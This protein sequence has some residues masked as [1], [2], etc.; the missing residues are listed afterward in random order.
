MAES[1]QR[2][3]NR[4]RFN[5]SKLAIQYPWLTLGF[6]LA[7]MVAGFFAFSSLKYALFP[8]V[9]FPVVV[10][11]A[12]APLPVA[13][14]TEAQVT[15]PIENQVKALE[16][17][18]GLTKIRSSTYPGRSVVSLSFEVGTQLEQA[19]QAVETAL[20]QVKLP[21]GSEYEVTPIN[22]NEA[23]VV[24]YAIA[25]DKQK[26]P[27][28]TETAQVKILPAIAQVPGVLKVNL[29]GV[30][31]GASVKAQKAIAGSAAAIVLPPGS[32]AVRWNDQD[33]LAFEVV[34]K[35]D[36][37]TLEVVREVEKQ[38][39]QL[40]KDHPSMQLTLAS[41]QAGYINQAT[42]STI[43]A[44]I[45]AIVL[46]V[47]VMYPFLWN[48]KATI[49]SALAIPTSLFGTFIVMAIFGFNLETITLLALALVIGIIVD[50]AI[51]DVE[52]IIR[53]IE[54][55]KPPR[56]AVIEATNEIGL[57][58]TAATLTVVAVF[59]PVALM[60]GV[61]GQFFRPFG[62]TVSA[63]VIIS[64]LVARTLSPMLSAYW[65]RARKKRHPEAAVAAAE[66]TDLVA[67]SAIMPDND[68]LP[69]NL[70][71]YRRGFV[72]WYRNVLDWSLRHRVLV[73][74]F[75]V[76]SFIAGMALIPFIPT[77]F[78]PKLDRGE[79]NV[80][81]TAP[82][83]TLPNAEQLAQLAQQATSGGRPP[84]L[85]PGQSLPA[86]SPA[87][88]DLAALTGGKA[89][90][91]NPLQDSVEV[92][93]QL[94]AAIAKNPAVVSVFTTIGTRQRPNQGTLYVKLKG[95]REVTTAEV[96]DQV[97]QS[98]PTL[99]DV[100]TSVEDIQFVDTGGEKPLQ[101]VLVGNDPV[102]LSKVADAVQTRMTD[103]PGLMDITITGGANEKGKVT[104]I[105]RADSQRVAYISANLSEGVALGKATRQVEE[106]ADEE[107]QKQGATQTVQ[108]DR[109]SDSAR[110][111]EIFDSFKG[112]LALA[113]LCIM[114][115]LVL[116]FKSLLDP[117]V[118][119]I[120]LPL[121]I[122]GALMPSV[123]FRTDFGMISIIGI[124]LL[125]GL[126]NKSAILLVDYINQL[127]RSG[128]SRT[129]A[130][131]IA[132][133]VRLRPIL[134]TTA[135]TLL[136]MVPIALGLGAGSELRTPMATTIM[137]GLVTST[138]LSLIVIPVFYA[139]FDDLRQTVLKR[140]S[141]KQ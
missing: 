99:K 7:V 70:A 133:P 5:I 1:P 61:I 68:V 63:A 24:S 84:Q 86:G 26:L 82:L 11:N 57:T 20:K 19:T 110:V 90:V 34:K 120:S 128:I 16:G 60:G 118:V 87:G 92:A 101:L 62:I 48:W 38:V 91:F 135:A 126:T 94:E 8:D 141:L 3:S 74:C 123:I 134:M 45:E 121:S 28:L 4:E 78:I 67:N 33:V 25:S 65:L 66:A 93:K 100:T 80:R 15:I 124:I 76:L 54:D 136:G 83:P 131:L 98:L 85:P 56:Q 14:K 13:T 37:N 96:Q 77:G 137:G 6:W 55:G 58:V 88:V 105:E 107:I 129:E 104:Q 73:I 23:A 32:S 44:L 117:L 127:R 102:V 125:M 30:P 69:A 9:T 10:V 2:K 115:V 108:R 112:T 111:D 41:T 46:S 39:A 64:L 138:I 21:L 113:I 140:L 95:D 43:D 72:G 81:Y 50:D 122:V 59:L 103:I 114:V 17:Q 40:Q 42:H 89:P 18:Q 97:R 22:L 53:H 51:V 106:I 109:G 12:Q 130:I 139:V 27:S 31:A 116:L 49:I 75:A 35:S 47:I 36:A 79:F 52:N 29:L 132:G 71:Q 119:A